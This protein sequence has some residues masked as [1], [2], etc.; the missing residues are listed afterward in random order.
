MI[1]YTVAL[2][3]LLGAALST[4]SVTPTPAAVRSSDTALSA[5]SGIPLTKLFATCVDENLVNCETWQNIG[6]ASACGTLDDIFNNEGLDLTNDVSSVATLN[7]HTACT[8]F[9]STTCTGRSLFVNG[10]INAL[11]AFNFDNIA[12]SFSCEQI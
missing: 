9:T 6:P 7:P 10:T 8:L 3:A 11:S 12:N 1:S 2:F 5:R 4:A